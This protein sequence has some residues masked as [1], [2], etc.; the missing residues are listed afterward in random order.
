M[1]ADGKTVG[2]AMDEDAAFLRSIGVD[3]KDGK[4][5]FDEEEEEF[6]NKSRELVLDAIDKSMND[7]KGWNDGDLP[8]LFKAVDKIAKRNFLKQRHLI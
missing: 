7:G 6:I 5:T 8:E 1:R 4:P 3:A 2:Q